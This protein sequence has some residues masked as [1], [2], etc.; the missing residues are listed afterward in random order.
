MRNRLSLLIAKA[1]SISLGL[2]AVSVVV[3]YFKKDS[4]LTLKDILFWVGAAPI[5]LLSLTFLGGFQGRT[6]F[7]YQLGSSSID[8]SPNHRAQDEGKDMLSRFSSNMSWI[9][10]GFL[11]W[12]VSYFI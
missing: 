2:G 5:A 3:W 1:A 11:L 6:N 12:I 7:G 10:A 9:L 4:G 8:K